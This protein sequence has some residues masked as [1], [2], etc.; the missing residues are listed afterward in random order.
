MQSLNYKCE[1]SS[2]NFELVKLRYEF[3]IKFEPLLMALRQ[4]SKL[5]FSRIISVHRENYPN[6]LSAIVRDFKSS[7]QHFVLQ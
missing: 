2:I 6:I 3:E 7:S 5:A 4:V 1:P